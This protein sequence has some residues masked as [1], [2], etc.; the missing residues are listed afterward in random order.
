MRRITAAAAIAALFAIGA[1]A[2][3]KVT[4][5]PQAK[6]Q[7]G[8]TNSAVQISPMQA[9][10]A[11]LDSARRITREE[12]IKLVKANKAVYVDVRPRE[13]YD[14]G[15]IKGAISIPESEIVTGIRKIAPGKLIITYCA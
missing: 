11:S 9:G 7:V 14:Q 1:S 4:Q 10:E 15:H 6:A 2:Q 13:Q 8:T 5:A 3:M 12:A